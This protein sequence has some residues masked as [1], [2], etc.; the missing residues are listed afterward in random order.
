MNEETN[1]A[2][3]MVA[4][5][6]FHQ[7]VI[8]QI[9]LERM[10]VANIASQANGEGLAYDADSFAELADQLAIASEQLFEPED[11]A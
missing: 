8:A 6:L 11:D 9:E 3:F 2:E 5:Q 7:S 1:S 10:R 4:A